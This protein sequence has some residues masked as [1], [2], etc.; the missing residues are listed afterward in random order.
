MQSQVHN[1]LKSLQCPHT[2]SPR[3]PY[4]TSLCQSCGRF[5][6]IRLESI[7]QSWI[8]SA[9]DAM[10]NNE[11]CASAFLQQL[12]RNHFGEL[13]VQVKTDHIYIIA[14][15]SAHQG[16]FI[17]DVEIAN[18]GNNCK[19]IYFTHSKQKVKNNEMEIMESLRNNYLGQAG[20]II[21]EVYF[22]FDINEVN[23]HLDIVND[24]HVRVIPNKI[25]KDT[26][27][28]IYKYFKR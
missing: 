5:A 1:V 21:G 23:V 28:F 2:E 11:I 9:Q 25:N 3:S 20:T 24:P 14:K 16:D 12:Q 18:R 8:A 22:K 17:N 19:D 15:F 26:F 7:Q 10:P 4:F 6:R 13:F 27:T